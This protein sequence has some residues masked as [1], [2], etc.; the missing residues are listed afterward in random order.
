MHLVGG[1]EDVLQEVGQVLAVSAVR[2][3][4]CGEAGTAATTKLVV[5]ALLAT[6]VATLA[7]LL[8]VAQRSGLSPT[9]TLELLASLPVTST[10]AARA[11]GAMVRGAFNPHFPV[12]LVTKDL[13]Y[14]AELAAR[15]EGT[16]PMTATAL[17]G[18]RRASEDGRGE[19]DLTAIARSY[20][21]HS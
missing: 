20:L 17:D 16:A 15:L 1:A 7:E 5:N 14:L 10:A 18:F 6:Q 2:V 19:Q 12:D 3:H 13:R 8:G 21:L 9:I 11:G 4:H